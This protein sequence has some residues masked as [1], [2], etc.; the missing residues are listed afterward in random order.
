VYVSPPERPERMYRR[1]R[2]LLPDFDDVEVLFLRYGHDDFVAG[3]LTESA[4]RFPKTSVN[5]GSVSKPED[6]LFAEDGKYDGLGVIEFKVSDIPRRI[7][8]DQGPTYIFFLQHVPYS[9]NYS[10]S[11]IWSD[12]E[13]RTGIVKKPSRTVRLKFR[14]HLSQRITQESIR[15]EAARSRVP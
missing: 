4:I 2:P 6:V 13:T 7:E 15:I 10:H 8:Q 1:D 12:Q 5:R 9:D 14:I 11:E 3:Q